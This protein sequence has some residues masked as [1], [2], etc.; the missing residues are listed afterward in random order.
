MLGSPFQ[1]ITYCG[2]HFGGLFWGIRYPIPVLPFGKCF[3]S[4]EFRKSPPPHPLLSHKP[5]GMVVEPLKA[6]KYCRCL[7]GDTAHLAVNGT[8]G[9]QERW[10]SFRRICGLHETIVFELS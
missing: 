6:Y 5:S 7:D 8:V 4:A 3:R 2:D 10:N 1:A 9:M